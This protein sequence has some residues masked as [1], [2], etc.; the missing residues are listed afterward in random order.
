MSEPCR[1]TSKLLKFVLS[2][3][4]LV[5]C[6]NAGVDR[7]PHNAPP[8]CMEG[9]GLTIAPGKIPGGEISIK[10]EMRPDW[11]ASCFGLRSLRPETTSNRHRGA[12]LGDA[13]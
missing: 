5:L 8:I 6:G 11:G 2:F 13:M 10:F 12:L 4:T 9:L 1:E 7:G 3:L